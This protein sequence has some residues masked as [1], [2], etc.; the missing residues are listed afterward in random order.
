MIE[1]SP[2]D[3]QKIIIFYIVVCNVLKK[4]TVLYIEINGYIQ[5]LKTYK[6]AEELTQSSFLMNQ[7]RSDQ[8]LI[9]VRLFATPWIFALIAEEGF[10]ISSCYSL[11][12]LFTIAKTWKQPKCPSTDEWI[13]M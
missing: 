11:A 6:N 7:I 5:K 1:M 10:L 8:S 9:R 13:K 4:I 12:A 2:S 3:K